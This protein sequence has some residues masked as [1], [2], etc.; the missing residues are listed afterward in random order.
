MWLK[1]ANRR[2]TRKETVVVVM[3]ARLVLVI[4]DA[5]LGRVTGV[6]EIL[7]IKIR[8]NHLLVPQPERV[9][10]AVGVLLEEIEIRRVVLPA[11]RVQ[12]SKKSQAGLLVDKNKS[13]KIAGKTLDSRS[14]R[15]EIVV[16]TQV[17][18][19]VLH[20]CFLH[21]GVS[22]NARRA[23]AHVHVHDAD[24]ARV[25]VVDVKRRR[26]SNSPIDR[27]ERSISM[28]KVE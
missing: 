19:F 7:Q 6:D 8:N 27:A 3:H 20:K 28:K 2:G 17:A 23:F 16:R 13:A 10:A 26:H 4:V 18:N 15:Y 11:V 9:E 12:V 5:E 24:F 22:I 21:S 1:H 14:H 25:Q